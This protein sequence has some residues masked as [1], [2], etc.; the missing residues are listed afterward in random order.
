MPRNRARYVKMAQTRWENRA[1]NPIKLNPPITPLPPAPVSATNVPVSP[2]TTPEAPLLTS[3]VSQSMKALRNADVSKR[4]KQ[5]QRDL[6]RGH[7]VLAAK[8]RKSE[9]REKL[10]A[11][12]A[13][14]HKSEEAKKQAEEAEKQRKKGSE[15]KPK[16]KSKPKPPDRTIHDVDQMSLRTKQRRQADLR[17]GVQTFFPEGSRI[18]QSPPKTT[19]IPAE[20]CVQMLATTGVTVN[21]LRILRKYGIDV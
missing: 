7:Q 19:P 15:Q 1:D 14:K 8:K 16:A 20:D 6:D 11:E 17:K 21:F 18:T 2:V 12:E 13:A 3:S 10:K 5:K 9:E 4:Q